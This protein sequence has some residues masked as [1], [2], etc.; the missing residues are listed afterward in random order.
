VK[1]SGSVDD[2]WAESFGEFLREFFQKF[3]LV[4]Y[5]SENAPTIA[6]VIDIISV[7]TH[8]DTHEVLL[9]LG[10]GIILELPV[11]LEPALDELPKLGGELGAVEVVYP[12]TGSGGFG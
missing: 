2:V 11:P 7:K 9:D 10:L 8:S 12:K 3:R 6:I 4:S 5:R 1:E